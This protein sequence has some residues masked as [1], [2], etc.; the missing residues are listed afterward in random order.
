MELF[1]LFLRLLANRKTN[2]CTFGK[3]QAVNLKDAL[4]M[5]SSLK[6]YFI[7]KSWSFWQ[8]L[9]KMTNSYW[10]KLLKGQ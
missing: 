10:I 2:K 6:F 8:C 3:R 7:C 4:S 5:N 1:Y 9:K